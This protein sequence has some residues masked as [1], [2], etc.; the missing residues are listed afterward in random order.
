MFQYD[1][2]RRPFVGY[3]DWHG[4]GYGTPLTDTVVT[5]LAIVI[6]Q[7]NLEPILLAAIRSDEPQAKGASGLIKPIVIGL[8]ATLDVKRSGTLYL[9]INDSAGRLDDNA[10]TASVEITQESS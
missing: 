6:G 1:R 5:I 9:R 4:P 2:I 8:G 3:L 7:G 10:G